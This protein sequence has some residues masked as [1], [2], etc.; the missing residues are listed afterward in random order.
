MPV[1][2]LGAEAVARHGFVASR[3]RGLGGAFALAGVVFDVLE[4]ATTEASVSARERFAVSSE[5]CAASFSTRACQRSVYPRRR[6]SG[7]SL[8]NLASS[9]LRVTTVV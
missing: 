3:R 9:L 7:T 5:S 4:Y 2:T 1:F 8:F 6:S